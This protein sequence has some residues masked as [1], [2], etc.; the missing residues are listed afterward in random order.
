MTFWFRSRHFQKIKRSHIIDIASIDFLKITKIWAK[1]AFSD[2]LLVRSLGVEEGKLVV[3]TPDPFNSELLED[4]ARASNLEVKAVVSSRKEI[5]KLINEFFGFKRSIA[6]A[7]SQF[8]TPLVDLGNLE[9]Y[10][11]LRTSDELPSNDQHVVNAVNHLLSYAFDQRA[12]DIH[13]EPKRE[14]SLVRMRIDGILHTVHRLP[15]KVHNAIVSRVKNLSRLDMAEKRRPQDGRIKTDR[16][17]VEVEIRVSTVPVAFG[18]KIVM[19]LLDKSK[20]MVGL[21]EL[22]M[23]RETY[24]TYA[25]IVHAP[26]G[27][28]IC[29]GL[30]IS[31]MIVGAWICRR[32]SWR[33]RLAPPG[34]PESDHR[35]CMRQR[36]PPPPS[37]ARPASPAA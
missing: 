19:R 35:C 30:W 22:G 16:E 29:A 2:S 17:G 23:P 18:E 37:P 13:I 26:Y 15:K 10:V 20:S 1:R 34:T 25:K 8:S 6:A 28:V 12:S 21:H 24:N 9:Q 36:R 33:I 27:M 5:V 3:A 7:E 32:G 4:I 11:R 31:V 14:L